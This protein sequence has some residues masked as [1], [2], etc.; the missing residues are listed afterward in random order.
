MIDC[1][2]E[3]EEEKE[4]YNLVPRTCQLSV[5]YLYYR[6]IYKHLKFDTNRSHHLAIRA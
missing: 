5:N 6:H 2:I 1:K 4:V 3:E